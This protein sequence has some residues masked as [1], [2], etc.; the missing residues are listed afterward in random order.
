M[1]NMQVGDDDS[2]E[3]RDRSGGGAGADGDGVVG[4]DDLLRQTLQTTHTVSFGGC[5]CKALSYV[6]FLDALQTHWNG[7]DAWHTS[8]FK[9]A[10]G[11]SSGCIAALC[12]VSRARGNVLLRRWCELDVSSVITTSHTSSFLNL[13]STLAYFGVDD[14]HTLRMLIHEVL[15]VCGMSKEVTF[16]DVFRLTRKTLKICACNLN[17]MRTE[18]F[19]HE[20]TPHMKVAQA[21]YFSMT[22]PYIFRPDVYHECLMVDGCLMA[23][24]PIES[25]VNTTLF[26]YA[27]GRTTGSKQA[28]GSSDDGAVSPPRIDDIKDFSKH[29][30][31]CCANAMLA[32][33]RHI[34][35]ALPGRV[36]HLDC[37]GLTD[38]EILLSMDHTVAH[39]LYAFGKRA[40]IRHLTCNVLDYV[41]KRALNYFRCKEAS[42]VRTNV[43]D[44][45]DGGACVSTTT[46]AESHQLLRANSSS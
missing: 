34:H 10:I 35:E 40:A 7:F 24:V 19:S 21:M 22:I 28:A 5:G 27:T 17:R 44:D 11:S 12:L 30:L 37:S 45:I 20:N 18:T 1:D 29:I 16:A 6:G 14:G 9:C 43:N 33:I 39:A 31:A 25:D 38:D 42:G 15:A 13:N 2:E 4:A 23:Y 32:K 36:I 8:L 46:T 26:V 41:L 3:D